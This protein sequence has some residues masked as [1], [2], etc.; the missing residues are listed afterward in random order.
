MLMLRLILLHIVSL[1]NGKFSLPDIT[2]QSM[3]ATLVSK[4]S[5]ISERLQRKYLASKLVC[6]T[7]AVLWTNL[8]KVGEVRKRITVIRKTRS[9]KFLSGAFFKDSELDAARAYAK[10]T[11]RDEFVVKVWL[12]TEVVVVVGIEEIR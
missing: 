6:V 11:L 1:T 7:L 3:N 8:L 5:I 2:R 12:K 4:A 10:T 9:G